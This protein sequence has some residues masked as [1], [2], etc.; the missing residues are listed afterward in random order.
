MS[1]N[2]V[3]CL[4]RKNPIALIRTGLCIGMPGLKGIGYFI[5]AHAYIISYVQVHAKYI[6]FLDVATGSATGIG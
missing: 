4:H 2:E 6:L 1:N 3:R 5:I